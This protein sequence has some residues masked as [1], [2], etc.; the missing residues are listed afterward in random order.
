MIQNYQQ[1]IEKIARAS[2]LDV[3]EVYRKVEAKCAK[4]SGLISKEGSAQI[5]A[6]E[7]GINFDKEKLKISELVSGAKKVNLIG[8]IIDNPIINSF[9]TKND[10]E[11]KVASMTLADDS[12]NI[13][14]VLWDI[15][16]ISLFENSKLKNGDFVEISNASIRNDELHLGSFSDIK[17]SNETFDNVISQK[18]IFETKIS[19]LKKGQTVKIRAFIV[20]MFEPRFFEA[21]PNCG[22]KIINNECINHGSIIPEKKALLPLVLDD[23]TEN[24]RAVL[25]GNDIDKLGISK[26]DLNNPEIFSRKKNEFLGEEFLFVANVRNNNIFNIME[27]TINNIEKIDIDKLIDEFK[28]RSKAL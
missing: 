13:R 26:D 28:P 22:K 25:F 23:G 9:R 11:G 24:I 21:C 27:M 10:I 5:V 19:D 20:Q 7:L 8:K 12:D 4:L 17:K 18:R 1:L 3:E 15:N 14:L 2:G 16:H 6:S